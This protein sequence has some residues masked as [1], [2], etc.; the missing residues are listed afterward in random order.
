[1]EKKFSVEYFFEGSWKLWA[2][3]ATFEK[4]EEELKRIQKDHP[5]Y[6]WVISEDFQAYRTILKTV[7]PEATKEDKT[8]KIE[9]YDLEYFYNAD[10]DW[11]KYCDFYTLEE[12]ELRLE[13]CLQELSPR[14]WRIRKQ[15]RETSVVKSVDTPQP[16]A[17]EKL[18][19]LL[20]KDPKFFCTE[21]NFYH[22]NWRSNEKGEFELRSKKKAV[23]F[24]PEILNVRYC[25]VWHFGDGVRLQTKTGT[26]LEFKVFLKT[27]VSKI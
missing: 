13:K 10:D 16:L 25:D 22:L 6:R 24:T 9:T 12:A 15:V 21:H 20:D 26:V 2:R 1:M 19:A 4:A 11:C 5:K 3:Y 14:P 23:H 27:D 7:R 8:M 17:R 18:I